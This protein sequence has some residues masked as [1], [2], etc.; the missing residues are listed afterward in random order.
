VGTLAAG[1]ASYDI[2][3]TD[4]FARRLQTLEIERHRE[5]SIGPGVDHLTGGHIEARLSA[6]DHD[7]AFSGVQPLHVHMS[8]VAAGTRPSREHDRFATW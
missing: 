1:A 8:F 7:A 3:Q 6:L 5:Q 4:G 2:S